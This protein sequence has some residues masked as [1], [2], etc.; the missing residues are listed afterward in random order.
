MLNKILQSEVV[1][2]HAFEISVGGLG[3][4]PS[5][6][7]ARVIW[8]GVEAPPELGSIQRG[9]ETA[10]QRLGYDREERPFSPHLTMG[11]V[12]RNATS[13]D[14][15]NICEVL[16][17]TKVGFLGVTAVT[18]IHIYRSDLKP[19]GAVYTRIF[20]AQIGRDIRDKD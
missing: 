7:H 6:R 20:T 14:A 19:S 13:K 2:H 10:M 3:A 15:H 4:F 9:I 11:R 8:V 5:A 16:E 17:A 18:E 1:D 12:S